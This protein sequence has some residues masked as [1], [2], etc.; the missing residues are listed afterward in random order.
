MKARGKYKTLSESQ[1][2]I[3]DERL[4][5]TV[6]MPVMTGQDVQSVSVLLFS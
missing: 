6:N 4:V 3:K 5:N 2:Q 1:K